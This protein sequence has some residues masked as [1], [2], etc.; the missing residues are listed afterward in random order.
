MVDHIA[1]K[2][3]ASRARDKM[4][5][6]RDPNRLMLYVYRSSKHTYAQIGTGSKVLVSASTLDP[7]VK[8]LL[9]GYSGNQASAA[10]VGSVVAKR[11]KEAGIERV[12][13]DR[14]GFKYHGRVKGLVDAA[15]EAGLEI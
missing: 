1:R 7:E 2:R 15:R 11:A 8:S 14:A 9:S 4:K 3:R 10:I 5:L 6:R 12:S 13:C